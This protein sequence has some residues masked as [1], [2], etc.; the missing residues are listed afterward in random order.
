[1]KQDIIN[2]ILMHRDDVVKREHIQKYIEMAD[3]SS[4]TLYARDMFDRAIAAT[5]ELVMDE[6]LDPWDIDLVSFSRQYLKKIRQTGAIDLITAGRIVL[7]AWKVLRLQ[8]DHMVT[9]LERKEQEPQPLWDEIPDWYM[10]DDEYL[11][12]R[13]VIEQGPPIEEK[14]RRQGERKV[15]LV[16]LINAFEEVRDDL[17]QREKRQRRRTRE[18]ERLAAQAE[19]DVGDNAHQEDVEEEIRQVLAKLSKLNGR[20]IPLQELCSQRDRQEMVMVL[21]SLLFLAREHKIVLWQDNVP[22]GTIYVKNRHHDGT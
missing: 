15:T 3:G 18:Q 11:F 5:F 6:Q 22:Y 12:T 20:A 4:A 14:V 21:S 19:R 10:E 7:M 8:S 17:E 16:E 2:H 9:V 13:T 1:M